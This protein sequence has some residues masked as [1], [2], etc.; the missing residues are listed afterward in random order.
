MKK[1]L[2]TFLIIAAA[3]LALG[4]RQAP[5]A[6]WS[7]FTS[8]EGRFSVSMPGP[9]APKDQP[10]TKTDPKFGS[11]T[12]HLLMKKGDKGL[13]LA[14]WVDYAPG[15]QVNVQGELAANRDNFIKGV[16]A[17]LLSERPV[18]LDGHPGIEFTAESDQASF[19][20]RVY[21]VGQR[22]YQLIAVTF[23]GFDDSASVNH[24]FSSFQLKRTDK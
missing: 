12:T 6:G 23:K 13:F 10:T 19:R 22:P 4:F 8:E 18:T 15:V 5:P 20:S 17:R 9:D 11:Y 24:F 1:S 21:V 7:R 14:G 2:T 3:S 16:K